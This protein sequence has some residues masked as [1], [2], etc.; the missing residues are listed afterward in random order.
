MNGGKT[1]WVSLLVPIYAHKC[2]VHTL[3]LAVTRDMG[4]LAVV[5]MYMG[6]ETAFWTGMYSTYIGFTA[7]FGPGKNAMLAYNSVLLGAGQIFGT[8]VWTRSA[9]L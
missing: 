6:L 5:F 1:I 4:M 2:I 9:T 7:Q 3:Q 8:G